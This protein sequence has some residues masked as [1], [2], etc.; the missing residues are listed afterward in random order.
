MA[1][2]NKPLKRCITYED[3]LRDG[4]ERERNAVV[5]YLKAVLLPERAAQINRG[6]HHG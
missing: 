4:A 2:N 5:R 1:A 6:D 3:G